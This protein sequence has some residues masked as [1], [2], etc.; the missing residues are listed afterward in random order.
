MVSTQV[1]TETRPAIKP[2]TGRRICSL[3]EGR[4]DWA[5]ETGSPCSACKGVGHLPIPGPQLDED[6]RT[7]E[8]I[9]Q[10]M[11]SIN[12]HGT[13]GEYVI[14][15]RDINGSARW[16][17][18]HVTHLG[19]NV[20]LGRTPQGRER[21]GSLGLVQW[22]LVATFDKAGECLPDGRVGCR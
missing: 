5:E 15:V 4:A 22:Y 18:G 10:L 16:R 12:S 13:G 17:I 20:Y 19:G 9:G 3:C 11:A 14:S 1:R 7:R 2:P 8:R 6:V 21:T